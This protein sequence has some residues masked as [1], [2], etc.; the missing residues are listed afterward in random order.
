MV[1]YSP[2]S[3]LILLF[4]I[5][6]ACAENGGYESIFNGKDLSQWDHKTGHQGHW[7]A[8]DW[9]IDYDGKSEEKDK[10]LWS[11][12]E[13]GDFVL[14][15]DLMFTREPTMEM[16]PVVLPNGDN[17]LN[18]DGSP[19][20]KK[21]AYAGDTGIYLRGNSKSQ[22]NMGNR[23]VG[24]GEIY[25]YRA[26]KALP[27]N[28]RSGAVPK[29]NADNPPGEWNRFIITMIGDKV[30]VNLNGQLVIDNAVL[31][32]IPERGPIALQD[33]HADNNT[34]QFANLFIKELD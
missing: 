28:V 3:L 19:K 21:V 33:D 31:P 34:F 6:V 14:I 15:A 20:E 24:S 4:I 12:K 11:K 10:S 18:K 23:P 2:K 17:A 5:L 7:T 22:V 1:K 25:G 29:I 9:R 26:D 32:G 30:S 13:Y 27:G 8:K 16:M